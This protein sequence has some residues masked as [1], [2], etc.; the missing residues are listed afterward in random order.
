M[1]EERF[2]GRF[3]QDLATAHTACMSIQALCNIF[4]DRIISSSIWPAHSPHLNS[5]YFF[6]CGASKDKVY[7]SKPWLE[8][9]KENILRKLQIF[10]QNSIKWLIRTCSLLG[11][12]S[13]CEGRQH[14][15]HLLWPVNSN[16]LIPNIIDEQAHWFIGKIRTC[17]AASGAPVAMKWSTKA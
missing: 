12:M 4:R 6:F 14:F 2:N 10:L 16:Y 17:L 9:M 13:M 7:N 15:Q 5:W 11:G 1:E 3:E 8:E